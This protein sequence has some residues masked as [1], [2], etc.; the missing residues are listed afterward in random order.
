MTGIADGDRSIGVPAV[1]VSY[2]QAFSDCDH[3]Q[4]KSQQNAEYRGPQY[5]CRRE[6]KDSSADLFQLSYDGAGKSHGIAYEGYH[7]RQDHG[8]KYTRYAAETCHL[9]G[10]KG[11]SYIKEPYDQSDGHRNQDRPGHYII[12]SA[13]F[14]LSDFQ[15]F[16]ISCH[17][18]FRSI[19]SLDESPFIYAHYLSGHGYWQNCSDPEYHRYQQRYPAD[20]AQIIYYLLVGTHSQSHYKYQKRY[21]YQHHHVGKGLAGLRLPVF[22]TKKIS[23][24]HDAP[25]KRNVFHKTSLNHKNK[26]TSMGTSIVTVTPEINEYT[27]VLLLVDL[28]TIGRQMSMA[29]EPGTPQHST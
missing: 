4:Y 26:G 18:F 14:F 6:N 25:V 1:A 8:K 19:L 22:V 27:A 11:F 29:E 24:Y 12:A 15:L 23:D 16:N 21:A 2:G 3:R 7:Q 28:S 5:H 10:I 9:P 17:F 20:G 13:V